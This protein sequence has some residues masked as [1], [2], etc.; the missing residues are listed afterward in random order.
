YHFASY[1]A[2]AAAQV[3][4]KAS[5]MSLYAGFQ[6]P[7]GIFLTGVAAFCLASTLWGV[8][9]AVAATVAVVVLP[10][11][12]QQGLANRYLSY[13][14]I[15]QINLG[16]LYGIAAVA[17]AWI[18][19]IFGCRR[20]KIGLVLLGYVFLLVCAFYKAHIFVANAFL[21]LM[22]PVVFYRSVQVKWRVV[23]GAVFIVVFVAAIWATQSH[24]RIPVMR[25]DGSGISYYINKLVSDFD[26][27]L[28]K[29]FF[30]PKVRT[31]GY[32]PVMAMYAAALLLLCT[33]G[34][35]LLLAPIAFW[36]T[37]RLAPWATLLFPVIIVANYLVMGMGLALDDKQV[38][39]VDE[40]LN[41]PLVWAYFAVAAWAAGGLYYAIWRNRAPAT[42]WAGTAALA[43]VVVALVALSQFSKDLQLF[44]SRT[45][46][47]FSAFNG[48]PVC[49]VKSAEFIKEN[50]LPTDLVQESDNDLS[51]GF[52]ALTE[53]QLFAGSSTFGGLTPEHAERLED[54]KHF[55]TLTQ[56]DQIQ[57]FAT[58][59]KIGW[60]LLQPSATAAWPAAFVEHAA[61]TCEGYK[62]FKF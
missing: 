43:V 47:K 27:G 19:M 38:G 45:Y 40:L 29:E 22:Y 30:R 44:P 50:S 35:W 34:W 13:N 62:V 7:V 61:F 26:P 54:L 3:F 20:E 11:A 39:T 31:G 23:I 9:P 24:P 6:L 55:L 18:F 48:V 10:D 28:L 33:F 4:T 14:F 49:M 59:R 32:K 53:R 25:L 57:S 36:K 15:A 56:S 2:P 37:R 21:I 46:V 42:R 52:T 8:W 17:L 60:Y 16:M 41:R 58:E 5:A 12:Y 51:F 1:I